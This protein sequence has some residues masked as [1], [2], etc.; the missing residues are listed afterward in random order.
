MCSYVTSTIQEGLKSVDS[1]LCTQCCG[2]LDNILTH[3]LTG[4]AKAK[5]DETA[6]ALT[7]LI[8]ANM[9]LFNQVRRDWLSLD[10]E[11]FLTVTYWLVDAPRSADHHHFRGRVNG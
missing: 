2:S 11:A 7:M 4:K 1:Q 3:A 5:P 8:Q 9:D 6:I 10:P